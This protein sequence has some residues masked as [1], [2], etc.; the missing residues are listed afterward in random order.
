MQAVK[1]VKTGLLQLFEAPRF[2]RL[3]H[4]L[5]FNIEAV[6]GCT[7]AFAVLHA[8]V[9]SGSNAR[10]L[11]PGAQKFEPPTLHRVS[12]LQELITAFAHQCV[13][14]HA[15]ARSSSRGAQP[16]HRALRPGL[17]LVRCDAARAQRSCPAMRQAIRRSYQANASV[18]CMACQG[19]S[20][21]PCT[22]WEREHQA[23]RAAS[24]MTMQCP[25]GAEAAEHSTRRAMRGA[26]VVR[27]I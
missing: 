8:E 5:A 14:H 3:L 10:L 7:P 9:Q 12:S 17:L 4:E 15:S 21:A 25:S 22:L 6:G 19:C 16:S 20:G 13:R 18:L 11:H 1:T 27:G 2:H 23:L 24:A 26:A